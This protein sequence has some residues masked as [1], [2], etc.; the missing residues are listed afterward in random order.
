MTRL[1]DF[2]FRDLIAE[3]SDRGGEKA[4][5]LSGEH[6]VDHP[7]RLVAREYLDQAA[8]QHLL[9]SAF[10]FGMNHLEDRIDTMRA[11]LFERVG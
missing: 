10:G 4:I 2:G 8:G 7:G 3:P 11:K 5:D 1:P 6:L 9:E